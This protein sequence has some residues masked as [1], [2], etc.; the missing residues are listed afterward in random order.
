MAI[1][2][3]GAASGVNTVTLPAHQAGDLI[4]VFAFRDGS[5]AALANPSGFTSLSGVGDSGCYAGLWS[6]IATSSSESVGTITNATTVLAAVYRG[7]RQ[8]KPIS[9]ASLSL[10]FGS[11]T[12]VNYPAV[13]FV[14][15]GDGTSWFGAAAGHRSTNTSLETPPAGMTLRSNSV[16][17]TDEASIFDTATGTTGWPLKTVSVGGTASNWISFT[18]EILAAAVTRRRVVIT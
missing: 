15:N 3:V 1:S 11:G 18:Y 14:Y 8:D 10:D 17:A 7:V 2:F 4:M 13:Q 9:T 6:K 12:T 16:D 5:T